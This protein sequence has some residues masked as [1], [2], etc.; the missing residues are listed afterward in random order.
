VDSVEPATIHVW[1]LPWA[2][3]AIAFL[4]ASVGHGG[5]TGYLALAAVLGLAPGMAR[6]GALWMNC[7]VAGIAFFKF[8][9]A[10]CFDARVFFPLAITST[11]CAWLG[12]GLQLDAQV[13]AYLLAAVLGTAGLLLLL[14]RRP[15]D[16]DT[17]PRPPSWLVALPVG[18]GLGFLAGLTGVGGGVF[19]TPLLILLSWTPAKV[20]GGVSALFILVNSVSGLL[21]LGSSSLAWHPVYFLVVVLGVIGAILGSHLGVNHLRLPGFRLI[22]ALVLWVAA[23]KLVLTAT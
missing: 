3:A 21:G 15:D 19:L 13:Y 9:Q 8:R 10:G 17:I 14:G 4:Y 23:L 5:A 1:T 18:A 22:L 7:F 16:A 11:P 2:V 6:P 20:A 12:S